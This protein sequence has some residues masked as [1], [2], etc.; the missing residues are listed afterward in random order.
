MSE[1]TIPIK[2]AP[3][4]EKKLQLVIILYQTIHRFHFGN[5]RMFQIITK[6]LVNLQSQIYL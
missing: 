5:K 6:H 2:T 1:D 4:I 3:P